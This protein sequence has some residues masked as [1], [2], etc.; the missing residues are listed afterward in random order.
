M[1]TL[2]P[3]L[4]E[5]IKNNFKPPTRASVHFDGKILTDL[6]GQTGD[7]LAVMLSGNTEQCRQ[8]KLLSARAIVDGTGKSQAE[9]VVKSLKEWKAFENVCAQVFDT[10]R[11]NT[12]WIRGICISIHITIY[13]SEMHYLFL[14]LGAAT[15]IEKDLGRPLLWIACR[16][17]ISELILK[18]A[19]TAVFGDVDKSPYYQKFKDFQGNW[20]SLDKTK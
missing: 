8:G 18:A 6:S 13:S 7:H 10:T 2:Q 5:S 17:H 19:W 20:D 4:A 15:R 1:S 14:L 11:A 16:H 12:G 9:E 3:L